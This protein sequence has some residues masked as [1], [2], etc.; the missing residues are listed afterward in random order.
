MKK[1]LSSQL[2]TP[3]I[4]IK[5]EP[6]ILD[7][8]EKTKTEILVKNL[9]GKSLNAQLYLK[10][11]KELQ[12]KPKKLKIENINLNNPFRETVEITPQNNLKPGVYKSIVKI[13]SNLTSIKQPLQILVLGEKG[14]IKIKRKREKERRSLIVDN[15]RLLLKVSSDFAGTV[16]SLIDK[17]SELNHLLSAY[18]KPKPYAGQNIW[19]GGMR[20]TAWKNIQYN[21]LY[22]EKFHCK[23]AEKK[24]WKG[25]VVSTYPKSYVKDLNGI[26]LKSYYLTKPRSNIVARI[27]RIENH[28]SAKIN[29]KTKQSV[30][31]QVGGS[32]KNNIV[33]F[34]KDGKIISRKRI[35]NTVQIYPDENWLQV[36][37]NKTGDSLLAISVDRQKSSLVLEDLGILGVKLSLTSDI[38]IDYKKN[39]EI[40]SYIVLSKGKNVFK[41]YS[42]LEKYQ[43]K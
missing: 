41:K 20:F 13:S 7:F 15:E 34:K 23:R 22:A 18:P 3:L 32:I 25:V 35:R 33:Y 6:W 5:L 4:D 10:S 24:G 9:R 26:F 39:L 30:F 28:S 21:R 29:L 43:I 17:R 14:N 37:N 27:L 11:S 8:S 2:V 19:F 36:T 12:F 31:V 40:L 16:Y 1:S 42:C 38:T